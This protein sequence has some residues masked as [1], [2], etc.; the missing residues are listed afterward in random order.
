MR[1]VT[2]RA[3]DRIAQ[4]ILLEAPRVEWAEA[5]DGRRLARRLRQQRLTGGG[6][7]C[8]GGGIEEGVRVS[9]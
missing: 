9:E 7:E 6:R 5:E 4:G 2:V 3:G 1:P 8:V